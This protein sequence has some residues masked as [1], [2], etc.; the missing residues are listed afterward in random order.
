MGVLRKPTVIGCAV[1]A[2][3]LVIAL[4][5]GSPAVAAPSYPT[6]SDVQKAQANVTAKKAEVTKLNTLIA[7][8]QASAAAKGKVAL[9]AGEVY[10]EAKDALADATATATKLDARESAAKAKAA[11]SKRQAGQLAAELARSSSMGTTMKLLLDS[12][13]AN[14]LLDSI[15]AANKLGQTSADI[16][17]KAKQDA[18]DAKTLGEQAKV[19]QAERSTRAAAASTALASAKKASDAAQATVK[20]QSAAQTTL[21][22]QLASLKGVSAS[23]EAGYLAGVAWEKA[24]AAVKAPPADGSVTGSEPG[25]PSSAAV[26]GAIAFAKAQLGKPYKL[27]GS[28]PTY[29]DCSGLTKSSYAA[30]GVYIGTHSATNQYSTLASEHRLV[31]LSDRQ[32]GDILWYSDGGSTSGTKYHVTLYIGNGQ[33]IEAPYPGSVVRIAAVRF[34]DLVPYAGRPTG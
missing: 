5:V 24:Q 17:D 32:P 7:G 19:A 9:Q 31:P 16:F 28:G 8:L 12:K 26:A 34:G 20:Q 1:M 15:G 23:T 13:N 22:A 25:L 27:D 11:K 6:W 10:L 21:T 18:N 3:A 4:A 29:W 14:N 33:M 2:S 30:V